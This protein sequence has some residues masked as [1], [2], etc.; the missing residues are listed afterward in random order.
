MVKLNFYSCGETKQTFW[1]RKNPKQVL[2]LKCSAWK[3]FIPCLEWKSPR[4]KQILDPKFFLGPLEYFGSKEILCPKQIFEE[5]KFGTGKNL[6]SEK[7]LALKK[8]LGPQQTFEEKKL[9][10]EKIFLGW[11]QNLFKKIWVFRNLVQK[12]FS[13]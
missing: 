3:G 7:V 2:S 9:G 6:W 1:E 12:N 5:K 10:P 13:P 11:K 4:P 8:I